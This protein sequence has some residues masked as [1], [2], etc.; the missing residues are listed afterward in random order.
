M[1]GLR[2]RHARLAGSTQILM[3]TSKETL[4]ALKL[5]AHNANYRADALQTQL[6]KNIEEV[7]RLKCEL[8]KQAFLADGMSRKAVAEADERLKVAH[9]C[10]ESLRREIAS[11]R[12]ELSSKNA[13]LVNRNIDL[14]D[15]KYRI[16]TLLKADREAKRGK[17]ASLYH[18]R[19]STEL[20]VQLL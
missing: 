14:A 20:P 2:A 17:R 11:L 7:Q 15:A 16:R 13:D 5:Q 9:G 1:D 6:N 4:S 3:A 18:S 10:I 12:S 8:G 19:Y